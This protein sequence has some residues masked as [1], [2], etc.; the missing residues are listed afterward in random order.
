MK[1]KKIK[2][3]DENKRPRTKP[4]KPT[5]DKPREIEITETIPGQ[6][7]GYVWLCLQQNHKTISGWTPAI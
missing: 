4:K 7:R 5:Q 2:S 3:P 6:V 1:K